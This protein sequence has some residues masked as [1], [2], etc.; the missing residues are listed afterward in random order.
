MA[1]RNQKILPGR[2]QL[3]QGCHNES[4]QVG[5]NEV[6]T[7]ICE[8]KR[9][10]ADGG[11]YGNEVVSAVDLEERFNGI[12]LRKQKFRYLG[13]ADSSEVK[14]A[15]APPSQD[16]TEDNLDS[17]KLDDLKFIADNEEVE[18]GGVTRKQDLIYKIRQHRVSVLEGQEVV[19]VE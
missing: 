19:E 6:G 5:T 18:L 12:G 2:F 1:K 8:L 9:Y 14:Q 7:P 4:I 13:P 15:A 3:L 11:E 17:M 16:K 10:R